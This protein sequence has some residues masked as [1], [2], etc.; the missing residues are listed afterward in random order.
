[1]LLVVHKRLYLFR[2]R[3]VPRRVHGGAA[4]SCVSSLFSAKTNNRER[5]LYG[6]PLFQMWLNL[7]Y[8]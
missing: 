7:I 1:M 4:R 5:E 8:Y 3:E 2:G 6:T